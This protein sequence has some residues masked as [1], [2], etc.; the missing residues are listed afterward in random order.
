MARYANSVLFT[1]TLGG[2]TDFVVSAAVQG[3]MTPA[4]AGAPT[5]VYKYRA[6]SADL[7]QWEIGLGTYTSGT[8]TLTRTTVLYNSSGTGT[9]AGQ[10]GA[11]TKINF[12]APPNVGLVVLA[13]ELFALPPIPQGRLTLQTLTP[14]MTTTQSAKT[15]IYYTPYNGNSIPIWDG[16]VM[17]PTTFAEL[18]VA[19]TDT[20]KNPAA[21]GASKMN[22][23]FVWNDNGT[24]RLSHGP[25]W[26]NDTTR[27]AGTALAKQGGLWTNNAAIT[28][29]PAAFCGTYVGTTRSNASSQLDWIFGAAAAGGTAAFLNVWNMYNRVNVTT[30]VSDSTVT[31]SY[32]SASVRAVNGST[33]NRINFV[34]GLAEEAIS[35]GGNHRVQLVAAGASSFYGFALDSATVMDRQTVFLAGASNQ[36]SFAPSGIY[37]PQVGYHFFQALEAGDGVNNNTF[38]PNTVNQNINALFRM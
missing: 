14:V 5:G 30:Q 2:T 18:S 38:V 32:S 31:Y 25:D 34:S 17:V 23:W 36:G 9:A 22:D 8:T 15:T 26:T 20:T 37:V 11:G 24:V 35:V 12:A 33:T 19:T 6:E 1:P 13:E 10:S 7:S 21:I 28:N 27:S 29:G 4:L 16:N 3:F